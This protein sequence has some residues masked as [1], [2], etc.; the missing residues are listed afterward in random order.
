MFEKLTQTKLNELQRIKA[1]NDAKIK[2]DVDDDNINLEEHLDISNIT[3]F[4]KEDL[5]KLIRTVCFNYL[6]FTFY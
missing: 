6:Y 4:T 2:L 3:S 5:R 1:A